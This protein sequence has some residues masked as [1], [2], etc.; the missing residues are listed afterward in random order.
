MRLFWDLTKVWFGYDITSPPGGGVDTDVISAN[1]LR[2]N[3]F[4]FCQNFAQLI[5]IIL[6][7]FYLF[8]EI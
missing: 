5:I 2:E 3:F 8:Q 7:T 4:E 6:I 1:P